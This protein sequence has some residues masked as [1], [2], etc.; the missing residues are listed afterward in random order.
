V[1]ISVLKRPPYA[2]RIV[3]AKSSSETT[4]AA[5]RNMG[6]II[7]RN[8]FVLLFNYFLIVAKANGYVA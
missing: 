6:L 3:K 4:V 8:M 1:N 7:G 2:D 5:I